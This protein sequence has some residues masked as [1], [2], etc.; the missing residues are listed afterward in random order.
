MRRGACAQAN[1]VLKSGGWNVSY[2]LRLLRGQV[3]QHRFFRR[4]FELA[5][6]AGLD[7]AIVDQVLR[8]QQPPAVADA[9]GGQTVDRRG[10]VLIFVRDR[11]ELGEFLF[12]DIEAQRAV[13][14][15]DPDVAVHVGVQSARR[16]GHRLGR[17]IDGDLFGLR[18][19]LGKT[20]TAALHV[21]A[22]VEPEHAVFVASDAVGAGRKA[23][24]S[25]R[26]K[27]FTAPV[28]PSIRAIVVAMLVC[29]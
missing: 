20:A 13:G 29:E 19:D 2:I 18:I 6:L 16:S 9:I 10:A 14:S 17:N 23:F 5:A 11:F 4:Q 12:L 21:G 24:W 1:G 28:L 3:F 26:L 25:S 15:S 7:I 27:F 22:D 8:H